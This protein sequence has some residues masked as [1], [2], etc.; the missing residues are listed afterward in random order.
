MTASESRQ[1]D[2]EHNIRFIIVDAGTLHFK[3]L[4]QREDCI[5]ISPERGF[6]NHPGRGSPG[7]GKNNYLENPLNDVPITCETFVTTYSEIVF[8]HDQSTIYGV[9]HL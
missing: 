6:L 7:L 4:T 3:Q 8:T 2:A 5:M 9:F 1:T